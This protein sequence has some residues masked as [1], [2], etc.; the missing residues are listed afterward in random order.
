L[1]IVRNLLTK[2]QKEAQELAAETL[3]EIPASTVLFFYEEGSPD[4]RGKLFQKLN[5]PKTAQ[6][7]EPQNGPQLTRYIVDMAL[8]KGVRLRPQF[9]E[10]IIE[11]CRGDLW[12]ISNELEKLSLYKGKPEEPL[13]LTEE[14][15]NLLITGVGELSIFALTDAFGQRRSQT[16]LALLQK[17]DPDEAIGTLAIIAGQYRNLILINEGVSRQVPRSQLQKELGLH[18]FV[19]EKSLDQAKGYTYQELI[20]CYKYLLMTDIAAKSS[21]FD[22]LVGLTTLAASL[23][24]KPLEIPKLSEVVMVY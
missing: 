22:P 7:F 24:K 23:E 14:E 21:F 11:R 20:D 19:F 3:Q 12:Q 8:E 5:Q 15:L 10:T 1:V 4:K 16:A 13:P 18:P 17:V 2:G 6:L 9:A